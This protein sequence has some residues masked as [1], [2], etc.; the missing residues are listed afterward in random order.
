MI[1]FFRHGSCQVLS[2]K[3]IKAAGGVCG[4][5]L[6]WVPLDF[7]FALCYLFFVEHTSLV[8][9]LDKTC[10]VG[11]EWETWETKDLPSPISEKRKVRVEI[12]DDFTNR[13]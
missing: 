5:A 1:S 2:K 9:V 10:A 6:G 13:C 7:I 12:S 4:V 3:Q 11:C 8:H